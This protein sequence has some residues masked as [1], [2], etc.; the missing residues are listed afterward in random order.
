MQQA[1][2]EDGGKCKATRYGGDAGK[3]AQTAGSHV[4][5]PAPPGWRPRAG[6]AAPRQVTESSEPPLVSQP[7][8]LAG[9]LPLVSQP[10]LSADVD[11]SLPPEV[12]QVP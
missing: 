12:S 11:G 7:E 10:L 2:A 8:S 3:P 4:A 6:I 9:S 1:K 5:A